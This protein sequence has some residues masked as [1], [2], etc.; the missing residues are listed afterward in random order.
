MWDF[1]LIDHRPMDHDIDHWKYMAA[2]LS[3]WNVFECITN[4][5]NPA[6]RNRLSPAAAEI[7]QRRTDQVIRS[8]VCSGNNHLL[9]LTCGSLFYDS[10]NVIGTTLQRGIY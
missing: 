2:L 3:M 5:V 8:A 10:T 1:L 4:L 6:L 9:S 7:D